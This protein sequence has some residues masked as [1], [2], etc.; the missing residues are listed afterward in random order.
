MFGLGAIV[1]QAMCRVR[2]PGA[3]TIPTNVT[4]ASLA[5]VCTAVL[6]ALLP[7][8]ACGPVP[9]AMRAQRRALPQDVQTMAISAAL[10]PSNVNRWQRV[11]PALS[12]QDAFG[13]VPIATLALFRAPRPAVLIIQINVARANNA[14]LSPPACRAPKHLGASGQG[15]TVTPARS[16]ARQVAVRI[17]LINVR[18]NN[19]LAQ[20]SQLALLAPTRKGVFGLGLIA[21][22]ALFRVRDMGAL[23]IQTNA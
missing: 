16:R 18:I 19:Q 13:L 23:T 9:I 5:Q 15:P 12:L 7:M 10:L 3:R 11:L 17:I 22:T 8:V 14:L 2:G 20:V 1:T 4:R 21:I 6:R